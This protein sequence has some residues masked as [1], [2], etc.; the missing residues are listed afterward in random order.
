MHKTTVIASWIL[1]ITGLVQLVLGLLFWTGHGLQFIPLHISNGFLF[2]LALWTIAG[3]ALFGTTRRG[4]ALFA[5]VWGIAMIAFGVTQARILIGSLHWLVR[6][7][8]L[9]MAFASF[10]IAGRLMPVEAPRRSRTA[11]AA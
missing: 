10:A 2:V 6:L 3:A 8:H 9:L 5:I 1:R 11:V 4:L 7:T